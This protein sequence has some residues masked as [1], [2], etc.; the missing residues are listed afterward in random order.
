MARPF[1]RKG[2]R[3]R[4]GVIGV[5]PAAGIGA[6]DIVVVCDADIELGPQPE[7]AQRHSLGFVFGATAIHHAEAVGP[8]LLRPHRRGED[9]TK[10]GYRCG[11]A[12]HAIPFAHARRA[13]VNRL[14]RSVAGMAPGYR[15]YVF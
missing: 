1:G 3:R 6:K 2:E 9:K 12:K 10:Y 15:V 5:V 8:G 7:T 11:A 13:M 14:L 4:H